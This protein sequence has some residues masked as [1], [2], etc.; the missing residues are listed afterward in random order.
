MNFAN[1]VLISLLFHFLFLIQE[2][3]KLKNHVYLHL[4]NLAPILWPKSWFTKGWSQ[5]ICS[6]LNLR[7]II[8][9]SCDQWIVL[10]SLS[11]NFLFTLYYCFAMFTL[12]HDSN[13]SLGK[14]V[15]QNSSAYIPSFAETFGFQFLVAKFW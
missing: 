2:I 9:C 6:L 4:K 7:T 15:R 5:L 1:I 10:L 14:T 12:L 13:D 8:S 3:F 11:T